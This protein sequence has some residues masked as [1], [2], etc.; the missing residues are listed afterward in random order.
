[1]EITGEATTVK[2]IIGIVGPCSAGKTTLI[3]SLKQLGIDARHIAQEH[4]YVPEMWLRM[5]N[6]DVLVYLDVSFPVSQA[7]R[8]LD[9]SEEDFDE[10]VQRLMHA[11]EHADL[12]INTDP[13]KPD[14]VLDQVVTFLSS[15][16]NQK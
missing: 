2:L 7:R 8:F 14:E 9:W 11:K 3:Q 5:T 6:P 10:Q 13:F 16:K 12:V 4:S 1:M 15:R